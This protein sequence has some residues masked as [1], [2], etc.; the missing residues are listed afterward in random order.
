MST[1]PPPITQPVID[2]NTL[3]TLPWLLFFN[4][5]FEG[6]AGES[7]TPTFV[8][9]TESGTPSITGRYYR[10]SQ[11]L[12]YF[13]ID[14]DPATNTSATAGTTYCDNFPLDISN[15]GLNTVVTETT[16]GAIGINNA[17]TNRIYVPSWSNLTT[18]TTVLGIAEAR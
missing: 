18:L 4:Q 11:Y 8:N 12:V 2:D 14:I 1:V 17:A 15:N 6:D 5:T 16:G 3:P 13:R 10:L 7:W 9:L